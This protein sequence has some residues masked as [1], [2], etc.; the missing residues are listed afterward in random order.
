[1]KCCLCESNL[2]LPIP[3]PIDGRSIT[4]AG[5]L[6]NQSLSKGHC[7]QCGLLQRINSAFVG[8]S[9]FYE[10]RY[11]GYYSRAGAQSYDAPRYSVMADWMC[12]A[13][14]S[15]EPR[16][17]LDVG[18]GAGWTMRTTRERFPVS[19][20]EG[21]EPSKI[22]ADLARQAG[23]EVHVGKIGEGGGPQKTY[24]LI[25][26][27]NVLQHVLSPIEFLD[28]LRGLLSPEGFLIL[29]CPDSSR[30]SNEM[31]WVD[32]NYSYSPYHLMQ[33]AQKTGFHAKTWMKNPDNVTLL[34]KQLIL[35]SKQNGSPGPELPNIPAWSPEES[36]KARSHY[37]ESWREIHR[38]LGA[39]AKAFSRIFNFGASSWTFLLAG[40][41]P[42]YWGK[43]DCCVVDNF[44]GNCLDKVVKPLSEIEMGSGDGLALG[45][46]PVTQESY[47][48]RFQSEGWPIVRWDK[49]VEA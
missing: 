14:G 10:E 1:M 11:S 28:E 16:S 2:W 7:Q 40:Y 33:L 30:P 42:D 46:N 15:F 31:L 21:I 19:E 47:A 29:T 32:H 23:F 3:D 9:D 18:C 35:L 13:L 38:F 22:N 27:N 20:I 49:Y 8:K 41:C 43:V 25:Y 37:A 6:L 48:R 45:V 34:D 36:Y 4:T 24:D 26:A 5:N 17:I 44:S 39:Q 12:A